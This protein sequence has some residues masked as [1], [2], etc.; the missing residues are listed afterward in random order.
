MTDD[1][2][3]TL[4]F[5]PDNRQKAQAML[6][7]LYAEEAGEQA[8]YQKDYTNPADSKHLAEYGRVW[9]YTQG[10]ILDQAARTGHAKKAYELARWLVKHIET[11]ELSNKEQAVGWSFSYNT[12]GDDFKD[13][14]LVTGA[15][16][17]ALNGLGKYITSAN[18]KDLSAEEQLRFKEAFRNVLK[19]LLDLQREDGLFTAGWTIVELQHLRDGEKYYDV[20]DKFGYGGGTRVKAE[21]VVTEHNVDMLA[22]LNLAI[23]FSVELG[24]DNR[25]ELISRKTKLTNAIFTKLYDDQQKRFITGRVFEDG[26]E[27][28][29]EHA[30]ID[31]ATWLTLSSRLEEFSDDE[32][33]KLSQALDYTLKNFVKILTHEGKSYYGAV[34]FLN[35]FEDPYIQ[36]SDQQEQ[37]YHLEATAGLILALM[38]FSEAFSDHPLAIKFQAEAKRLWL[39]LQL[40][41]TD[42]G[43][44]YASQAISN[45]TTTLPSS[46][47]AIW[48]LDAYDHFLQRVS[49]L[50]IKAVGCFDEQ[51][52]LVFQPIAGTKL[53]CRGRIDN[54]GPAE[55][56][57]FYYQ[58][59]VD[60]KEVFFGAH[61]GLPAAQQDHLDF[62]WIVT[63]V[64]PGI[65][66]GNVP[67]E[68]VQ[69]LE[70]HVGVG[71]EGKEINERNNRLGVTFAK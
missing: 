20:L 46:T 8:E 41:I 6:K 28:Q 60:Q 68:K 47:A 12:L 54:A 31:N 27:R 7:K 58:W 66:P 34:Y 53:T 64:V 36:P 11:T 37:V 23:D 62:S 17:W 56:G 32:R 21:N 4:F 16:A 18:F 35:Y 61:G 19:G 69:S 13:P 63:G 29:S 10:I 33:E 67:E 65:V 24:L 51:E 49:D 30:A 2:L 38:K 71:R 70:L 22:L 45:L 25:Q 40:F 14:R 50:R 5:N 1:S 39:N 48:Y 26:K 42:F 44:P 43:F 15:N 52:H 59:L 3:M 9:V 57:A 55:T